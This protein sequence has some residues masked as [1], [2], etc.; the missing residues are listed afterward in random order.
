MLKETNRFRSG[1]KG[2]G[3]LGARAHPDYFPMCEK[4]LK[5]SLEPG[6]VVHVFNPSTGKAEVSRSLESEASL[7]KSSSAGQGN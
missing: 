7:L 3:N 1:M 5:T 2:V 6:V 4:E